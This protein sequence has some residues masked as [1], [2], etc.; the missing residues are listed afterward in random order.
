MLKLRSALFGILVYSKSQQKRDISNIIDYIFKILQGIYEFPTDMHEGCYRADV[1][2]KINHYL[3]FM[4]TQ[5]FFKSDHTHE[6]NEIL[7]DLTFFFAYP[8]YSLF[9]THLYSISA[10]QFLTFQVEFLT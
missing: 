9:H 8:P 5:H 4:L 3:I 10:F 2:P 6:K 7:T 1:Q